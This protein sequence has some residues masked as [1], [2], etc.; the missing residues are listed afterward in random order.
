MR[1]SAPEDLITPCILI[2][3]AALAKNLRILESVRRRAGCRILLALKA[4]S[5]FSAFPP[6]RK[7]LDGVAASSLNEAKLGFAE[8][9]DRVHLCAPAYR[10][11]EFAEC[12]K[13]SRAVVFNSFA[14][15]RRWQKIIAESSRKIACGIRVNPE[16][17][18]APAPIY[19][20]CA[21]QSRFGVRRDNFESGEL[22]GISGLHTHALCGAGADGLANLLAAIEMRF[23]EFLP[24]MQ[25]LN[26]GGGHLITKIGCDRARACRLIADFRRR[27]RLQIL[28]EPGEAVV[29]RAGILITTVLDAPSEGV[30]I[31]DASAV[32]HMPEAA[33]V[34]GRTQI[35]GAGKAGEF[36]HTYR[37]GGPTCFSGD[38]FGDYSFKR[39]LRRGD[40]LIIEDA[41]AYTMV[42]A[43]AFNGINPPTIALMTTDG[44]IKIVRQFGYADFRARLS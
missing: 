23:G 36:A 27:H 7:K 35:R 28:I 42:R 38:V 19:D 26:L 3:E 2:S 39:K 20:P 21:P 40:R 18:E 32:S 44:D 12:L 30:A 15:W 5:M 34:K 33:E 29:H 8:F 41:A 6:M 22:S 9:G 25:W 16:Y 1:I 10:E 31:I 4:F 13:K 24:Q 14:E 11:D 43:V 17:S 37:I